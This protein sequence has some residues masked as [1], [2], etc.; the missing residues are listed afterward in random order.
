MG[1]WLSLYSLRPLDEDSCKEELEGTDA[2]DEGSTV[3]L[4]TGFVALLTGAA[5]L[6]AGVAALE[7]TFAELEGAA[8]ELLA[9]IVELERGM[10]ADEPAT[11][12]ELAVLMALEQ[13]ALTVESLGTV[14]LELFASTSV[15]A[16]D[17]TLLELLNTFSLVVSAE[18]EML[19]ELDFLRDVEDFEL[20]DCVPSWDGLLVSPELSESAVIALSLEISSFSAKKSISVPLSSVQP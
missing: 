1:L 11:A 14:A 18:L 9:G 17:A 8:A 16:F 12:L 2:L 15:E 6:L 5:A 4:L 7:L 13:L 10:A 19:D 20:E 3:A